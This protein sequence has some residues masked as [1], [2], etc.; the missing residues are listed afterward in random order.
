MRNRILR[1]ITATVMTVLVTFEASAV[2]AMASGIEVPEE[3]RG[4]SEELGAQ[5]NICP[6]L[7]QAV[8]FKESGFRTDVENGGCTGL[9]QVSEKWHRERME[10]LGVTDLKDARENMTVGT[11]YLS[12][13]FG[14]YE[15][16]GAALME[17]NGDSRI[18][19]LVDGT[20]GLSDYA[21]EVLAISAELERR[22][23]K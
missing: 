9:M 14:R 13:L 22:N 5:Y 7:I 23:G 10:R 15:D 21:D 11:D 17:Y 1:S 20:G 16:A 4:I 2:T 3:I 12:E 8:C 19:K 18:S 6:E